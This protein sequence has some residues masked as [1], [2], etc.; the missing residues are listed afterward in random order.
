M[1]KYLM[2]KNLKKSELKISVN[3]KRKSK[4]KD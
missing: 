3:K 2:K 1:L 4:K